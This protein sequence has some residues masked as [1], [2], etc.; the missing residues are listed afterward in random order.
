M[1]LAVEMQERDPSSTIST[2]PVEGLT[3]VQ[4]LRILAR[5]RGMTEAKFLRI[6]R[7]D[8]LSKPI[9][10]EAGQGSYF[11]SEPDRAFVPRRMR[12][13]TSPLCAMSC[14]LGFGGTKEATGR[15]AQQG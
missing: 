6:A 1:R 7:G 2:A 14:E 15:R 5:E 13:F 8:S 11:D 12:G 3:D 9:D 4:L 10:V